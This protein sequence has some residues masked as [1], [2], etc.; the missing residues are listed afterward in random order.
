MDTLAEF[1][2]RHIR[3][4]VVDMETVDGLD[5]IVEGDGLVVLGLFNNATDK[6]TQTFAEV[7]KKWRRY[8][9]FA[10]V[11]DLNKA[12]LFAEAYEVSLFP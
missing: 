7:A 9:T 5:E 12:R 11:A 10:R 3:P 8:M 2:K 4:E 1:T 6:Y